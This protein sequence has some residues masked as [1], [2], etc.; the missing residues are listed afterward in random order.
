MVE[1]I[2]AK[3]SSRII[4]DEFVDGFMRDTDTLFLESARYLHRQP[5]LLY[6]KFLDLTQY[7]LLKIPLLSWK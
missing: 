3:F 6:I 7:M 5:L 2:A 4:S 1:A